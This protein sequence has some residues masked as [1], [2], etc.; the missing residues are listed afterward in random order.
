MTHTFEE[1][2]EM[3]CAADRAHATVQALRDQSDPPAYETAWQAWRDLAHEAHT[4]ITEHAKEQGVMRAGVEL[5]VKRAV[6]YT[7]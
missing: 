7:G 6:R 5:E 4:A 3:Q 2:L 1:L